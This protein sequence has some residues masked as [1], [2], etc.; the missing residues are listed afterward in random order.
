MATT[1]MQNLKGEKTSAIRKVFGG[2]K[3][4]TAKNVPAAKIQFLLRE[5]TYKHQNTI[6]HSVEFH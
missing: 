2:K 1:N 5:Q 6:H 3:Y 4:L